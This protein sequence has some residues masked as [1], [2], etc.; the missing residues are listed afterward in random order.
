MAMFNVVF[1]FI[2]GVFIFMI[3]SSILQWSKNNQSPRLTVAAELV[4]KDKRHHHHN[5]N[6][7]QHTSTSYHL[8]FRVK[9][10]D[11]MTFRV[12]RSDYHEVSEGDL[13]QLSFQGTRYLGFTV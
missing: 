9:S 13:G 11:T 4:D 6:G 3:I 1:I 5:N 10:G 7:H 12:S 2:I 8:V